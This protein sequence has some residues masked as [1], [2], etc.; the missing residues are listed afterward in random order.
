MAMI[1]K[2]EIAKA[3]DRQTVGEEERE[4]KRKETERCSL[5]PTR[6][7][8]PKLK[9]LLCN[10][11][12]GLQV[13]RQLVQPFKYLLT[14]TPMPISVN[15]DVDGESAHIEARPPKFATL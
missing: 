7:S 13:C 2:A 5:V 6:F 9:T 1:W 12:D 15:G 8:I 4:A 3:K 14:F 11:H 10:L